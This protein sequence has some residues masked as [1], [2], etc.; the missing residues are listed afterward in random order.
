MS[1]S[2]DVRRYP[3][4]AIAWY[5]LLLLLLC[6]FMYFVDSNILT[7]LVAPVRHDL[8]IDDGRPKRGHR[9]ILRQALPQH[10]RHVPHLGVSRA[11]DEHAQH[12]GHPK[13]RPPGHLSIHGCCPVRKVLLPFA[14]PRSA[15]ISSINKSCGRRKILG[16]SEAIRPA[17]RRMGRNADVAQCGTRWRASMS[18]TPVLWHFVA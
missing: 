5:G 8:A 2:E 7:L 11:R 10:R 1:I 3:S 4:P 15:V 6:Y 16:F 14:Q 18:K 9:T 12:H 17:T 13:H